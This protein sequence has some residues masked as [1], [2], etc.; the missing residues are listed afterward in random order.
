M[1]ELAHAQTFLEDELGIELDTVP[2]MW[3]RGQS[4][5]GKL[6]I[7]VSDSSCV[8]RYPTIFHQALQERIATHTQWHFEDSLM[9]AEI[10]REGFIVQF[11]VGEEDFYNGH[12]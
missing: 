6:V 12:N 1:F 5:R 4:P 10:E 2:N 11:Y 8:P 9:M 3:V 7:E